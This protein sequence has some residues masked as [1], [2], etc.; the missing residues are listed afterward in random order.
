MCSSRSRRLKIV[1]IISSF[2]TATL[3][4]SQ[5]TEDLSKVRPTYT[6]SGDSSSTSK[7]E[8]TV[9]SS[10]FYIT[11]IAQNAEVDSVT[12]IIAGQNP[13]NPYNQ[14]KGFRIQVY[15]G[16]D[17]TKAEEVKTRL[18]ELEILEETATYKLFEFVI[19]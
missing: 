16:D 6:L 2:L 3:G 5:H 8:E 14:T 10:Q 4:F 19:Q 11:E 18:D 1:F 7:V 15:S 9:D 12:D 13:N 17:K